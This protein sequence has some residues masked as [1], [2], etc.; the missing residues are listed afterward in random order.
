MPKKAVIGYRSSIVASIVALMM[1]TLP[2]LAGNYLDKSRKGEG[3]FDF[4]EELCFDIDESKDFN[5]NYVHTVGIVT[6]TGALTWVYRDTIVPTWKSSQNEI[7]FMEVPLNGTTRG[8]GVSSVV[9]GALGDVPA[10]TSPDTQI[11]HLATNITKAD[12]IGNDIT[13]IDVYLDIGGSTVTETVFSFQGFNYGAIS[14]GNLTKMTV[15]VTDLLS[16][17]SALAANE[18]IIINI[19]LKNNEGVIP[20]SYFVFDMQFYCIKE[21]KTPTLTTLGIYMAFG[22][23]GYIFLGFIVSPEYTLEGTWNGIK[24]IMEGARKR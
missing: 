13:R 6:G 16:I 23:L 19:L 4:D 17:N 22:G 1:L 2:L 18:K 11:L 3:K 12:I 8:Y 24:K 20:N 15:E 9:L 14:V 7:V 5:H 10:T 21:I